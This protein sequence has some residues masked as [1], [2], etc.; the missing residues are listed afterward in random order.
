MEYPGD[1]YAAGMARFRA[2]PLQIKEFRL[3][4]EQHTGGFETLKAE[5]RLKDPVP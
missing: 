3:R 1:N 5:T 4:A 2:T